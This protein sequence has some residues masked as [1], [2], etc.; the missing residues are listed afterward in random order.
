MSLSGLPLFRATP[1]ELLSLPES[2]NRGALSPSFQVLSN[3]TPPYRFSLGCTVLHCPC[4]ACLCTLAHYQSQLKKNIGS[5][6]YCIKQCIKII[7]IYFFPHN[8]NT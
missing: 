4:Q 8:M 6:G 5:A 2:G 3:A 1:P 7:S